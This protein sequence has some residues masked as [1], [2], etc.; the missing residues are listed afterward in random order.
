MNSDQ[1]HI[2]NEKI[3]DLRNRVADLQKATHEDIQTIKTRLESLEIVV[4]K[5]QARIDKIEEQ[6]G[7]NSGVVPLLND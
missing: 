3:Y 6:I 7:I 4:S 2:V 1:E 5:L